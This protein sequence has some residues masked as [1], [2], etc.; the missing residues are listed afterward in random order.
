MSTECEL[1]VLDCLEKPRVVFEDEKHELKSEREH[2]LRVQPF[3]EGLCY[4]VPI[5]I[6]FVSICR[7]NHP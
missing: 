4:R 6:G 1:R 2:W 7:D 5:G 3:L